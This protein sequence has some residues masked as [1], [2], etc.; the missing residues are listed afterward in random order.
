MYSLKDKTVED[1]E[2]EY[3]VSKI[4]IFIISSLHV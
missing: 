4:S 3:H 2:S 1:V